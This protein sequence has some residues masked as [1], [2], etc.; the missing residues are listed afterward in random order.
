MLRLTLTI[1]IFVPLTLACVGTPDG[2]PAAPSRSSTPLYSGEPREREEI[3]FLRLDK[4]SSRKVRLRLLSVNGEKIR[5]KVFELLPGEH[6]VE[7][8]MAATQPVSGGYYQIKSMCS[9]GFRATTNADYTVHGKYDFDRESRQ[10]SFRSW[11]SERANP[12][13]PVGRLDCSIGG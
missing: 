2:T 9:G 7:T 4:D 11:I 8:S 5:G 13:R 12:T 1:C 10:G 3:S 6:F